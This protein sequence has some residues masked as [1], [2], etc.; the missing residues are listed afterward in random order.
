MS[1]FQAKDNSGV[2]FAN[3]RKETEKHPNAKGSAVIDGVEYWVSAWTN[4]TK[5]GDLYQRLEFQSKTEAA[6]T[7]NEES[8]ELDQQ[9]I[10]F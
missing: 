10:P 5:D 9:D 7:N 3:P 2:L 1:N 8:V 4:K 6:E